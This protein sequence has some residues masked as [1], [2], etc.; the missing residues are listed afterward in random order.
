MASGEANNPWLHI[1]APSTG[2]R[3]VSGDT[4]TPTVDSSEIAKLTRANVFTKAQTVTPVALTDAT[5]IATDASLSNTFTV[6]LGGNRLLS[7]PTNLVNGTIYNWRITQDGTGG[8][9]LI[10]GTKFKWPGGTAPTLTTSAGAV[11]FI[12]GQYF[13]DTDS[14]LCTILKGLA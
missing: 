8:R 12:S 3:G 7:N 5:F 13:S 4:D 10:Y 11:N 1:G 2:V 6:T 9:A 14:I